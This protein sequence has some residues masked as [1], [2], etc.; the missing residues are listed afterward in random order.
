[1]SMHKYL[2]CT[3]LIF[4]F[5]HCCTR[6][7]FK[8]VERN[9]DETKEVVYRG[10]APCPPILGRL[11]T[12]NNHFY[13]GRTQTCTPNHRLPRVSTYLPIRRKYDVCTPT[14]PNAWFTNDE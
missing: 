12:W 7:G 11:S 1:M 14:N 4:I 9:S 6:F 5:V 2:F 10:R 13:L 8:T 3:I